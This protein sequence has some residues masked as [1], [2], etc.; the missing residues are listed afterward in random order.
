M[1]SKSLRGMAANYERVKRV[2]GPREVEQEVEP[3]K[4]RKQAEKGRQQPRR[5]LRRSER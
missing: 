2:I 5:F 4:Q 1:E 3:A